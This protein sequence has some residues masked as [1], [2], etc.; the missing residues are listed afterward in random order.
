M[1]KK[2]ISFYKGLVCHIDQWSVVVSY[3]KSL[4]LLITFSINFNITI[5]PGMNYE[6]QIID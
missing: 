3:N 2:T 1:D 4:V 5:L 6:R